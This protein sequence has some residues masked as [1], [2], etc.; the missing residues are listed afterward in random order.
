[1][2]ENIKYIRWAARMLRIIMMVNILI[3]FGSIFLSVFGTAIG[4]V[5]AGAAI[6]PVGLVA[7]IIQFIG[8][9]VNAFFIYTASRGL[10]LMADIAFHLLQQ[11][12]KQNQPPPPTDWQARNVSR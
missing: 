4:A 5:S 6:V 12:H 1:M 3:G 10:E 2:T 8:I 11:W 7:I 9:L